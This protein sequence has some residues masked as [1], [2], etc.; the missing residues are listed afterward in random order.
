MN[1]LR[2][3]ASKT[4]D[5]RRAIDIVNAG[6]ARRYRAEKRFRLY[7]IAAIVASLVFLSILF[8]SIFAKGY[9]A[10]QQTY[11]QLDVFFDPEILARESLTTA[12][13]PGLV[14][15]SLRRMFPEVKGRRDKRM[16]YSMVSSGAAFQLRNMV[17]DNPDVIGRTIAIWVP[18][19]DDVDMFVKGHFRRD[20]PESDRRIKDKQ[21]AW[22]DQLSREKRIEKQFNRVLFTASSGSRESPAVNRTRLNRFSIRPSRDRRSSQPSCLSLIRLSL[23]GT[24]RWICPLLNMSTSSSAGTQ[25]AMV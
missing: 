22:L 7:G 8:I 10:F 1:N 20:V 25:S 23:S 18:A 9:P 24:S 5:S 21:I 11:L 13:Y 12:D 6:L 3:Q 17:L 2:A 15:Q 14:K 4:V 19:D 16:L